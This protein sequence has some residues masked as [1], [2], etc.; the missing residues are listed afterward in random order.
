L[1]FIKELWYFCL[2]EEARKINER[3]LQD[4]FVYLPPGYKK[5]DI[6]KTVD[7]SSVWDQKIEAMKQ[8][9]SQISDVVAHLKT[10]AELPKEENYIILTK[11]TE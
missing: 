6:T 4:Y 11:D 2:T 10:Y 5:S 9:E 7:V 1:S 8:H 3:Y